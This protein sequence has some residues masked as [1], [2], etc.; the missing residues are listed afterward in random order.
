MSSP[1]PPMSQPDSIAR[2]LDA[3][4]DRAR[5]GLRVLED[6]CRFGLN[7]GELTAQFKHLRQRLAQWHTADLRA[8]RDTP[9]DPTDSTSSTVFWGYLETKVLSLKVFIPCG[10]RF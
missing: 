7:Q 6:W 8:A 4:L 9:S 5:E 3:N 2:I 10:D 1:H